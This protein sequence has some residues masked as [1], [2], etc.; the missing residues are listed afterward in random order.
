VG[1]SAKG[2]YLEP[3]LGYRTRIGD[4]DRFAVS[5]VGY[6]THGGGDAKGA[7][8]SAT[9]GGAEAA[10]ELRATPESRWIELH[11][12]GAASLTG[13][14]ASGTYCIDAQGAYG[15]DCP[16]TMPTFRTAHASGVYPAAIGGLALDFGRHLRGE[17]HGGRVAL[18]IGGGTMPAVPSGTQDKA[19]TYGAAGL[20]LSV[21][22]GEGRD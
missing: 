3:M 19:R 18:T 14:S 5:A 15:V 4:D 17:F 13:V 12:V 7:S 22:F 11:V 1:D 6:A 21:G 8:Y 10:V 16:D 20:A 2:G 9:R